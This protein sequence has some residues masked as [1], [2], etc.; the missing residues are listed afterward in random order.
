MFSQRTYRDASEQENALPG[1]QQQYLQLSQGRYA[2]EVALLELDGVTVIRERVN[3]ALEQF[4]SAPENALIFYG[5]APSSGGFYVNGNL[6]GGST[7][8]FGSSWSERLAV[9]QCMSDMVMVVLDMQSLGIAPQ[10]SFGVLSGRS[11][12]Q[13]QGLYDWLDTLLDLYT[14]DRNA[15]AEPAEELFTGMI[16]DRMTLLLQ[17]GDFTA[18]NIRPIGDLKDY[19]LL[20]DWLD[21]NPQEPITVTAL[22]AAL[23]LPASRLRNA[24]LT[25]TGHRLDEILFI[26][27][28]NHARR[29]LISARET[30]RKVSDIALDWGFFHW[31]RFATRYREHFGETPS[32]TLRAGLKAPALSA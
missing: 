2:G 28:L 19:R 5:H 4:Y 13:A 32:E 21:A 24:C 23:R 12:S 25:F 31:G 8:G 15:V 1:W 29:D 22:A 10:S 11:A 7:L 14:R 27:R 26:R 17:H 30:R 6:H 16:K 9:S 3:V 20:V 18:L